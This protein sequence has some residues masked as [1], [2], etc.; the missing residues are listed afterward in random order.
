MVEKKFNSEIG[1]LLKEKLARR[2]MPSLQMLL[3]HE[4]TSGR[5]AKKEKIPS[6]R[7]QANFAF[8]KEFV[9]PILY[10]LRNYTNDLKT[11]FGLRPFFDPKSEYQPKFII[12]DG[13]KMISYSEIGN[14]RDDLVSPEEIKTVQ[15]LNRWGRENKQSMMIFGKL[16]KRD[17]ILNIIS[18]V[19]ELIP[20]ESAEYSF[21]PKP[22]SD[23]EPVV[24]KPSLIGSMKDFLKLKKSR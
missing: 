19:G 15:D 5:F 9:S 6:L 24:I 10:D 13:V 17:M 11:D 23:S 1:N 21:S 22:K 14:G 18:T 4:D 12:Y 3:L 8:L 7:A 2:V 16:S 20:E